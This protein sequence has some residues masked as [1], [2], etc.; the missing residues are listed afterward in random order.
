V[1]NVPPAFVFEDLPRALPAGYFGV[2]LDPRD[3][4]PDKPALRVAVVVGARGGEAGFVPLRDTLDAHVILAAEMDAAD[5][6]HRWFELWIQEVDGLGSSLPAYRQALTNR[7]LDARWKE[8]AELL[9]QLGPDGLVRTGYE[10]QHPAPTF[11][12]TAKRTIVTPT[13]ES[14]AWALCT[15]DA[16]LAS[17][18]LQPYSSSTQRFLYVPALAGQSPFAPATRDSGADGPS[19]G[20]SIAQQ[21]GLPSGLLPLNPSGGLMMIRPLAPMTLETFTDAA[22]GFASEGVTEGTL[23]SIAR[24]VASDG[25]D[26]GLLYLGEPGKSNRPAEVLHL[27]LRLLA[28]AVRA[29]QSGIERTQT[30]M[31]NVSA[32][33][34][35]VQMGLGAST[36]G[37]GLPYL[38]TARAVLCDSGEAVELPIKTTSASFFMA[39]GSGGA[40]IY[41]PAS[42][43]R[44]V[45]GRGLLRIRRVI[46]DSGLTMVEATITS[47]ERFAPGRNDLVWVHFSASGGRFDLY[48]IVDEQRALASGEL[49]FKTIAQKLSER[50]HEQLKKAEGIPIQ[51]ASFEVMP[52]LSSPCDLYSLAVLAVRLLLVGGETTL[53]V[54]LDETMSLAAESA[55][56]TDDSGSD[57]GLEGR[58]ATLLKK[59]ARWSKSIGPQRLVAEINDPNE[60]FE[61]VPIELWAKV[62]AMLVRMFPGM[63]PESRCRDFGDAPVGGLHKVFDR[64]S[65]DLGE[66]LTLSRGIILGHQ[67]ANRELSELVRMAMGRA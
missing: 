57:G 11:I 43:G 56:S 64:V 61:V 27:K 37:A 45:A 21:M 20:A 44:T 15:S 8:R 10:D 30:P 4:G 17:S 34:F 1:S 24:S 31:L 14:G 3:G 32:S 19:V 48:G 55:G 53:A 29:V 62:L 63:G 23:R 26:A 42:V 13:H 18:G 7:V 16:D 36:G 40:T 5:R 49:R 54:A 60:G 22:G 50:E 41:T 28:D 9:E 46:N 39:S 65:A 59:D 12:D 52:Q 58:I 66:L 38:W 2:S 35:R 6:V 33:S 67:K 47:A 25:P 51:D